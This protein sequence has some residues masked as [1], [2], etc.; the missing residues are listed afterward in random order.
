GIIS[1]AH[2]HAPR[3]AASIAAHLQARLAGIAGLGVNSDVAQAE[4]ERYGVPYYEDY[5]DLLSQQ[6]LHAVYVGTEPIR[7]RDVV[8]RAAAH[9]LH[10]LC[11]KPI[12]TT[13]EEADAIVA[14]AREAGI[15]LMV[16]FNPRFQLPLIKVKEALEGGD[17][18]ELVAI[19]AVKYG[20]LPTKATGPQKAGWFL[21]PAQAGGGGFLDIG[22]HAID[23]LRWLAGTEAR[24]IYAHI[25][26]VI[27]DGL[28]S[29]DLG[30]MTVEFDNGVVAALSAGWANPDGYPA[31]LDVRFEILTTRRAFL[32]D[33]PYHGFTIYS[34][35]QAERRYWWRRDVDGL[36]D[37]FVQAIRQ[38][39][40]PAI[41]GEDGRAALAI[42]LA[43]YESARRGE[44]VKLSQDTVFRV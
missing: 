6:D 39:R 36:V 30:T 13:L 21:D 10:V 19:Y 41:T 12:A 31:W 32:I 35:Q 17:A 24:R 14:L 25:G 34:Q 29:D 9:E 7:H 33:S 18:G 23:A 37:E 1:Y 3:Y 40:E 42:A 16:P 28:S 5:E 2:L 26:T 15:K 44:V 22:I 11:D 20:R 38:D 4:A 8:A 27:H 43:A